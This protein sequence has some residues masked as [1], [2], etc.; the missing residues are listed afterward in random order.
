MKKKLLA[1]CLIGLFGIGLAGIANATVIDFNNTTAGDS[2]IHYE[3]DGY[4]LDASGGII[5]LLSIF[6]N[7]ASNYGALFA[8]TTVQLTTI[9]GSKFDFTSFL[10][11]IQLNGAVENSVKITSNKGGSFS[12]FIA[13]TYNLSG[14]QWSNLDWVNIEIGSTGLTANF[15]DL[16]V[17]STAAIPEPTTILLLGTGLVGVAGAARRRKKNQA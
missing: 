1:G 15:D 3:E 11:P 12:A 14:G 10:I 8:G 4:Q 16:T 9:D 13:Q 7:A 2:Y 5:P 17:N 6:G